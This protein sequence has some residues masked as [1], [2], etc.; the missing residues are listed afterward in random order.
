M[1]CA[2]RHA[3]LPSRRVP[4]LSLVAL[5]SLVVVLLPFPAG[6]HGAQARARIT[7]VLVQ[8]EHSIAM[9]GSISLRAHVTTSLAGTTR[10]AAASSLKLQRRRSVGHAWRTVTSATTSRATRY[11][12]RFAISPRRTAQFRVVQT[13]SRGR[14]ESRPVTVRVRTRVSSRVSSMVASSNDEWVVSGHVSPAHAHRAVTLQSRSCTTCGWAAVGDGKTS[15]SS[16]YAFLVSP[17]SPTTYRVRVAA[18]PRLSAGLSRAVDVDPTAPPVTPPAPPTPPT[19]PP[20]PPTPPPT[21]PTPPPAP[22]TPPPTTPTAPPEALPGWGLPSWH[23]E[24]TSTTVDRTRWNVRNDASTSYDSSVSYASQATIADG[25]LRL[26]AERMATISHGGKDR[27]WKSAY[28]DSVGKFS[29]RYGRW[30]MRAKLPNTDGDSAGLWPSFWLRDNSG[31][32]EVDIFEAWGT[33]TIKP[34]EDKYLVENVTSTIHQDTFGGGA[35]TK[36][37]WLPTQTTATPNRLSGGFHTFACEWTPEGFRFLLDGRLVG[38][39]KTSDFAWFTTSFPTSANIRIHYAVGQN[40]YG[41]PTA[42]TK[43]EADYLIDYVRV[44]PY[45]R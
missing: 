20:A 45:T 5:L 36:F 24:F 21:T 6:S 30:E 8:P 9:G 3:R 7:P 28:L 38:E 11:E 39:R 18:R 19:P 31:G 42:G 35:H 41:Q 16:D 25:V 33:P 29:Q 27:S 4:H 26:R 1:R 37:Q 15:G 13:T 17:T 10:R 43:S 34:S 40:Y 32:G 2:S 12:T 44:Y 23:D 22:P 14:L